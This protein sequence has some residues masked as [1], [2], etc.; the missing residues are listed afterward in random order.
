MTGVQTCA[1]PIYRSTVGLYLTDPPASGRELQSLDISG[2][3]SNSP[4]TST[5]SGSLTGAARIVALR[6]TL[7]FPYGSIDIHATMPGGGKVPLLLLSGARPE[8]RR[9]YWLAEP[10]E[11][12]SGSKVEVTVKP[13]PIETGD[14][15]PSKRYAL[16]IALDYVPQ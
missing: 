12:P 15:L 8:W 7:D 6:P 1:L 4:Q 9:R 5:F 13:P 10:V 2:S 11:L 3:S 16:Q 14:P